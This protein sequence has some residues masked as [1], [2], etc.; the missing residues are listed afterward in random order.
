LQWLPARIQK[1]MES[2]LVVEIRASFTRR[3][4]LSGPIKILSP[5]LSELPTFPRNVLPPSR[6]VPF[7]SYDLQLSLVINS[8]LASYLDWKLH[9]AGNMPGLQSQQLVWCSAYSRFFISVDWS[10][11]YALGVCK[12]YSHFILTRTPWDRCHFPCSS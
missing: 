7:H 8:C 10:S 1:P 5:G 11:Y 9:R 12:V 3:H 2:F 6:H 4:P